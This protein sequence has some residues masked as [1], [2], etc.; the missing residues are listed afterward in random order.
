MWYGGWMADYPDPDSFL[1]IAVQNHNKGW[2]ND[3]YMALI[4][5]AREVM[6]RKQRMAIYR[7]A[8][9]ILVE[10]AP[11]IPIGY[12][13]LNILVKPWV[14]SLPTTY[15]SWFRLKETIIEPH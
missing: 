11:I 15:N 5:H 10:E 1:R 6:D 4:Q 14:T 12:G 9:L 2:R 8:E 13:R 3:E 7:Q